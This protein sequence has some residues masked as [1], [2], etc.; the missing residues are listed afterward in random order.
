MNTGQDGSQKS[1]MSSFAMM[2]CCVIMVVPIV[3]LFAAGGQI[4]TVGDGLAVL[5]PLAVCVGAH[6]FMHKF[7]GKS[8]HDE[9]KDAEHMPSQV[10]VVAN[11]G[12]KRL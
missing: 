12:E 6:M 1:K 2:A 9:A 3:V 11:D 10:R 5:A 4:S 7:L 8:C